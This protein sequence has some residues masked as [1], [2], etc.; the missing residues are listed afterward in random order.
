MLSGFCQTYKTYCKTGDFSVLIPSFEATKYLD[1]NSKDIKKNHISTHLDSTSKTVRLTDSVTG[2]EIIANFRWAFFSVQYNNTTGENSADFQYAMV[3][4]GTYPVGGCKGITDSNSGANSILHAW[5][6]PDTSVTCTLQLKSP[7]IVFTP[8]QN[9]VKIDNLSLGYTLTTGSPLLVPSGTYEG[10]VRYGVGEADDVDFG[11]NDYTQN[12]I[13]IKIKATVEHAFYFNFPPGSDRVLLSPPS[14]WPRYMN[15]G[16][17]PDSLQ[18]EIP[19]TLTS[20]G[21]FNILIKCDYT[22][23]SG[24]GLKNTASNEQVPLEVRTSMPGFTTESGAAV[25]NYV[26]DANKE[27]HLIHPDR[28]I[29]NR[30]ST[31]DFQVKRPAVEKMVREPGSTWQGGVTVIFDAQL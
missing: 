15:G 6:F 7:S 13:V 22:E 27:G 16:P 17:P 20:S 2:K 5:R 25:N 26:L 30:R 18:K 23:G 19:F 14:G 12:E 4:I 28:Y 31:L 10:E 3:N 29:M 8:F 9:D 21:S 24:C 1:A 11:A